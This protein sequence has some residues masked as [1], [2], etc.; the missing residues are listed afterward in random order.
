MNDSTWTW[1]GGSKSVNQ[2]GVYGEKDT[3]DTDN[4]P[5][6]RYGSMGWYDSSRQEFWLLGG[7]GYG[8]SSTTGTRL[9]LTLPNRQSTE[10]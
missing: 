9:L 4:C 7:V 2:P 6:A 5:G 3:P 1:M 8:N 10:I